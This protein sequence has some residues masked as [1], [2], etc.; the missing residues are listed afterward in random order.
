MFNFTVKRRM[1][2]KTTLRYHFSPMNM[3]KVQRLKSTL[4]APVWGMGTPI[5]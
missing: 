3:A 2:I 1:Q 5:R 4:L